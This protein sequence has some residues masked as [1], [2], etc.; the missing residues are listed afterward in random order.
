MK[1][2]QAQLLNALKRLQYQWQKA[3]KQ[4][5]DLLY[6]RFER[7]FWPEYENTVSDVNREMETVS[8]T[9]AQARREVK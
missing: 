7:E 9:I 2:A 1:Q 6:Y 5:R 3:S 4:W 8:Q